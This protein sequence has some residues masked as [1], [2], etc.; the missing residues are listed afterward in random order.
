MWTKRSAIAVEAGSWLTITTVQPLG[1]RELARSRRRR[2]SRSPRRA[3]RS[4]RRRAAAAAGGRAPRRARPAAARRRRA[5]RAASRASRRGRPAR[6]APRRAAPTRGRSA[7]EPQPDQLARGQL[8]RERPLVVLVEVADDL[9]SG[10]ARGRRGRASRRSAPKTRIVPAEGRSSPARIRRSVV[11]PEPLGPST[12]RISP[13]ATLSVS[14]CSAAASPSGVEWT[15]KTSWASTATAHAASS[16]A[17]GHS[18]A[19]GA[20]GRGADEHDGRER[21]EHAGDRE[22]RPV[23]DELERR[24][25][26]GRVRGQL[27]E[28]DDEQREHERRSRSRRARRPGRA[29]EARRRSCRRRLAGA[30]PCASRSNSSAASSRRSLSVPSTR[31]SSASTIAVSAAVSEHR[32]RGAGDRLGAQRVL[33]PRARGDRERRERRLA[34][35]RLDRRAARRVGV[36]PELGREAGAGRDGVERALE[37]G[38]VDDQEVGGLVLRDARGSAARRPRPGSCS[39]SPLTVTPS[40]RSGPASVARNGETTAGIC[41]PSVGWRGRR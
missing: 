28:A 1:G 8:G 12:V 16:V 10:S 40:T 7:R 27:D 21:R 19:E 6:A 36:Q 13:S 30:T 14:P 24:L 4:A 9:A 34:Q 39:W 15:R 11:L 20:P 26:R 37:R 2:G 35:A 3:R 5:V 17:R 23:R 18:A 29:S 38:P 25:G 31:P 33:E 32:Q 22:Q 41:R